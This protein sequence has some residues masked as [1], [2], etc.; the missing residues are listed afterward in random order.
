MLRRLFSTFKNRS[1]SVPSIVWNGTTGGDRILRPHEQ[2][3]AE[4]RELNLETSKDTQLE[5]ESI[6]FDVENEKWLD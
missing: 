1:G 4:E 5:Q 2:A 3:E 6:N